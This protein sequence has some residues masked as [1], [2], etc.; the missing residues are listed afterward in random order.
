MGRLME[1]KA[2]HTREARWRERLEWMWVRM[3]VM[4]SVGRSE[5]CAI[6]IGGLTVGKEKCELKL[7]RETESAA[8]D[9]ETW[10]KG[11]W[12][13]T[14]LS[15]KICPYRYSIQIPEGLNAGSTRADQIS[16]L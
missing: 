10:T 11:M 5:S 7:K 16:L 14:L 8:S 1:A 3:R 13:M 2:E 9:C 15:R 6:A 4:S 12:A